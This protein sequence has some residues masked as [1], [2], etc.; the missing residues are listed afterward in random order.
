MTNCTQ[1][2]LAKVTKRLLGL[3]GPG[4]ERQGE[5]KRAKPVKRL[6]KDLWASVRA[7]GGEQQDKAGCL[8][9]GVLTRGREMGEAALP[10]AEQESCSKEMT[11][12]SRMD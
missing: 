8:L 9:A 2:A 11:L 4:S 3:E 5:E 12:P 10:R 7:V 6:Q 1:G